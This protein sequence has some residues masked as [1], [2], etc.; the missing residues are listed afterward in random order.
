MKKLALALF[1]ALSFGAHAG[2]IVDNS[3]VGSIVNN[4]DGQSTGNAYYTYLGIDY[5]A[6]VSESGAYYGERFDGQTLSVVG[7]F[8]VLSGSPLSGPGLTLLPNDAILDNVGILSYG[9][10]NTVYG[11]LNNQIGEGAVSV[12]LDYGSDLFALDIVGADAGQ[13]LAQ[14]FDFNG[15]VIG[16]ITQ[17]AVSGHF[18]F[19]TTGGDLIW[20]VSLTNT[21]PAGIAYDNVSFTDT[22]GN[23]VPEPGTVALLGLS[24]IGLGA[25]R[26][27]SK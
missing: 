26:R 13:F 15:N 17:T 2:V 12:L 10:S 11:N 4:F 14:F 19:R 24:L 22:P 18:G 7:G 20:G 16:S 8:D 25:M 3:V 5:S 23:A 9:G 1:S 21:D 6:L 27:K